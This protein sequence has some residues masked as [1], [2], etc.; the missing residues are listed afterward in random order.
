MKNDDFNYNIIIAGVG[1]QGII[2]AGQIIAEAGIMEGYEVYLFEEHGMARRGGSVATFLRFG[3]N[4]FTPIILEGTANLL[5]SFEPSE[6]LRHLKF[7]NKNSIIILNTRRIIPVSISSNKEKKYPSLEKI[8]DI[9]SKFCK[10]LI[11]F[12]AT[13]L[14]LSAGDAITMN[15]VLLGAISAIDKFPIRKEILKE[16]IKKHSSKSMLE[17]NLTAFDFGYEMIL[18]HEK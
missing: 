9:L 11:P 12:D 2:F 3:K 15:T 17:S 14:A 8:S 10:K 6:A 18:E 13:A 7:M 1:G 4:I 5:V 16:C